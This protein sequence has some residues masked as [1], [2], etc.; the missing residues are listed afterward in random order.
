VARRLPLAIVAT[1]G[2]FN[3]ATVLDTG[4]DAP[5]EFEDLAEPRTDRGSPEDRSGHC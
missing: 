4:L 5:R 3:D 1:P 2:N